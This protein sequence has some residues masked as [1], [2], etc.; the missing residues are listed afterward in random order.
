MNKHMVAGAVAAALLCWGVSAHAVP[1]TSNPTLVSDNMTFDN[2]TACNVTGGV[3]L[4]CAEIDVSAHTSVSPPDPTN[5]DFGI[6]IQAAFNAG[7]TTEDIVFQYDGHIS[8]DGLFHDASMYF[9]GTAVSSVTE[10]IYNLANGHLIGHV[11]VSAPGSSTSVITLS[12]NAT[13]IR[14][15]KDIGL[16]FTA[17]GP[18]VISI[19]DQQFSQTVPEPAS[20]ALLASGLVGLGCLGRRRRKLA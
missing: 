9:N 20:L 6:R 14:M 5:G 11:V 4:T 17:P 3:A 7:T 13:D 8:G 19:V 15:V 18:T 16:N 1:I 10:D 12:E 2:F